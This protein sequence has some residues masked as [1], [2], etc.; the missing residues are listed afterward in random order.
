VALGHRLGGAYVVER[1]PAGAG[2]TYRRAAMAN[3]SLGLLETASAYGERPALRQGDLV[4]TYAELDDITARAAAML[5]ARGMS[6]G[7]RVGIMM[8]NRVAFPI[9][10][11]GILRAGGVVVP[12]NPLLKSRE[13]AFYLDDCGA[14]VIFVF[15]DFAEEASKGA[16]ATGAECVV[17]TPD[18][19]QAT[20]AE[21]H[22]DP[23]VA[24]RDGADTVL[25]L[26]TSGTTGKPK[27][28]ELTHAN[29]R[30]IVKTCGSVCH[31]AC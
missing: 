19:L 29:M 9:I 17:V 1:A 16:A 12:M 23:D 2:M 25:I 18:W 7:D 21:T 8:P 11:Y 22:P 24:E 5:R 15:E 26:Y 3:L 14:K 6:P 28:A 10:Y 27:G 4:L 13:V 30:G 31:A 20:L